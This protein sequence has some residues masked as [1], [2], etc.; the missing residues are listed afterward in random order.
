MTTKIRELAQRATQH[1][2][3]TGKNEPWIFEDQ[4]AEAI[5]RECAKFI[6]D[7]F[8]CHFEADEM[9]EEFLNES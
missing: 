5:V 4:F 6:R 9:I 7:T 8:D 3:V 1:C 2:V